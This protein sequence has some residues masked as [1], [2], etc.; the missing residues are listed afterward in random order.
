MKEK[1]DEFIRN[2][3]AERSEDQITWTVSYDG[4]Q[5]YPATLY[6]IGGY[7]AE[8]AKEFAWA[9]IQMMERYTMQ[10]VERTLNKGKS[11]I[12]DNNT[13]VPVTTIPQE[14]GM[15]LAL[16]N[17]NGHR[18]YEVIEAF[19]GLFCLEERL[20]GY[21]VVGWAYVPNADDLE[22]HLRDAE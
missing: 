5:S 19:Q 3:T 14:D 6:R 12:V 8:E 11:I 17:K 20:H 4:E 15:V 2:S 10:A 22:K 1:H 9:Y 18:I 21:N 7:T 16:L 13:F